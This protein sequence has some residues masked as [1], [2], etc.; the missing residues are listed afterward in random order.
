M[1]KKVKAPWPTKDV[2]T[3]I[4]D[5]HLWGGNEFDFYSGAGSHDP[6]IIAPIYL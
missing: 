5:R 2:M 4:Y 6:K 3:Q 1:T